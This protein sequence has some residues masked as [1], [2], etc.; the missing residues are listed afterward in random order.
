M[1]LR[2]ERVPDGLAT[3]IRL[4]GRRR[5]EHLEELKAQINGAAERSDGMIMPGTMTKTKDH[6]RKS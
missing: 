1:T 6:A 4:I 5:T 2:I 3:T